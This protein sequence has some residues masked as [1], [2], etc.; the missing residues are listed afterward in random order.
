MYVKQ[1]STQKRKSAKVRKKLYR[2]LYFVLKFIEVN[3]NQIF[4]ELSIANPW[5]FGQFV[6][7]QALA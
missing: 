2:P 4:L 3:W 1:D 5:P 6:T 7:P